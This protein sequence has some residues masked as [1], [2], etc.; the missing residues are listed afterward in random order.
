MEAPKISSAARNSIGRLMMKKYSLARPRTSGAA[1]IQIGMYGARISDRP[2]KTIAHRHT[3]KTAC[4]DSLCNRSSSFSPTARDI[5]ASIAMPTAWIAP[6][7]SQ[8][9]VV[10][11]ETAAVARSPR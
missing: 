10:V 11:V 2:P 7:I 5:I 8:P 4:S 3:K 6:P 9:I 1:C